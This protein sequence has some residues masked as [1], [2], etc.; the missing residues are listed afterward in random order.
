MTSTTNDGIE[1]N[2][3]KYETMRMELKNG[4]TLTGTGYYE[5]GSKESQ[6]IIVCGNCKEKVG[7]LYKPKKF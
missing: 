1:T 3:L 5:P 6:K 4:S 2:I 7:T